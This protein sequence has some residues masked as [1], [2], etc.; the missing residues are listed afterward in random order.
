METYKIILDE[1]KLRQFIEWLPDCAEHEQYYYCLMSRKKYEP[2]MSWI[3]SDKSQLVR[4]TSTKEKL[5]DKISQMECKIGAY[6]HGIHTVPQTALALYISV[7]PR[8]LQKAGLR[9]IGRLAELIENNNNT[10]NPHQEVLSQIQKTAGVKKYI[11]FDVDQKD[12]VILQEIKKIVDG[13]CDVI[14]TRGG[15]HIFIRKTEIASICDKMWYEKVKKYSDQS[16]DILSP[17]VG[18]VQGDT[19]PKFLRINNTDLV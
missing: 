5:F 16:G 4:G 13:K 17:I 8:N 12:E 7:N 15:Y 6:K 9:S 2:T 18:C 11:T 19:S 14:E 10:S 1:D 3:K